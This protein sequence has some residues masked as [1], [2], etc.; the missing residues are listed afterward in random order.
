MHPSITVWFSGR[1]RVGP[2]RLLEAVVVEEAILYI[3]ELQR[4]L[5]DRLV[6]TLEE[7]ERRPKSS[8][9][10]FGG[11]GESFGATVGGG[12]RPRRFNRQLARR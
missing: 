9:G 4:Q 5:K 1:R 10:N 7:E 8:R 12:E 2:P 3:E 6:E 11:G